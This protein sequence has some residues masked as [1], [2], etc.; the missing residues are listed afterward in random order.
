MRTYK[1][2]LI[3]LII[4]TNLVLS[5]NNISIRIMA[6]ANVHNETDPCGWKKKP[7]GGLARKA[8]VLDQQSTGIDNFYIVD[9]GNL[10]F[11]KDI[12][13]NGEERARIIN[14]RPSCFSFLASLS[15]WRKYNCNSTLVSF[16]NRVWSFLLF[17]IFF[18]IWY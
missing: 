6:T 11:K 1:Q 15:A 12:P 10:F 18:S 2:I 14:G 4:F 5:N 16:A 9:A 13:L 3:F 7:L 17:S 8:T